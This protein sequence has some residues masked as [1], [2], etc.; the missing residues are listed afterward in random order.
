MHVLK[1]KYNPIYACIMYIC[2]YLNIVEDF[3][4]EYLV[5]V[6]LSLPIYQSVKS[7]KLGLVFGVYGDEITGQFQFTKS[8]NWTGS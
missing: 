3:Y 2:G 5:T 8:P 6:S 7:V 4:N 1:Y